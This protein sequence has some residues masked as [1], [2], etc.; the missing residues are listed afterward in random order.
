MNKSKELELLDQ[1][2]AVLKDADKHRYSVSKV[3]AAYNAVTGKNDPPQTC[4]SCLRNRVRTLREWYAKNALE[5]PDVG[6]SPDGFAPVGSL[7][8]SPPPVVD[9]IGTP[10]GDTAPP[11]GEERPD[12]LAQ[13]PDDETP[14]GAKGGAAIDVIRLHVEVLPLPVYFQPGE[15]DPQKGKACLEGGGSIKPGKYF[16]SD[17][18]EL[19]VQPGGK[20]T[21]KAAPVDNDLL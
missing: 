15:K 2:A 6:V 8:I 4:S 18:R 12:G 19:A 14:V 21:L 20:A 10:D 17:D 1:V 3:F 13:G 7:T 16:T 11:Q 9:P 5:L